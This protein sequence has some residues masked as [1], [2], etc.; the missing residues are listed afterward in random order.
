MAY[1]GIDLGTSSVKIIAMDESGKVIGSVSKEYPVYYPQPGWA[2]QNPEDWWTATRDGIRELL[3][4]TG[5]TG[6]K[7]QGIGL[8]GQM[9]G[10]VLLDENQQV[11]MPA[12]LWC[13]QRTQAECDHIMKTLGRERLSEYTGNKALTGFTAPKVLWVKKHHPD[14]HA[15]IRHILLPKDYIR[16]K[17]TGEFATD[18]SDASGTLFFDVA[19]RQWSAEMIDFL[20]IK[21]SSLP[22]CYES[23]E[24]TGGITSQAAAATGLK[25][26]TMV[27]GGGGDQA[28]GAVG[29]GAVN[30]G[31][32]SLALGT[33]GVVFACQE[34]Y[35]VD[36]ENRLHSFCHANG[37]W[38]VMGVMLSAASCL[39]WWVKE[40][41][42]SG[43]DAGYDRL[44]NEAA[45]VPAATGGLVFLPYLMGERTPHSDPY[46]RGSFVGLNMTHGRG[47]M[48]RAIMEG[49][50]F[51]LK[52]SFEIIRAQA[53]PVQAVRVS[54]GGAR[55]RLWRQILADILG[56]RVDLIGA[57]EGPAYGAA[58]LAAV[59]ARQFANVEEACA[60]FI[61][62]TDGVDP[63]P[64][65]LAPYQA[66]Y[67]VYQ[68]LYG[69]MKETFKTISML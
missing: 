68:G 50:G 19:R 57:V 67:Q 9:H 64:A 2:E 30:T 29:T 28:A 23:Y 41:C 25:T 24:P 27:V 17:L 47:H 11:L 38:H 31:T 66:M 51:G 49:V 55:S 62:V 58:I 13:D 45:N 18:V 42:Q 69:T 56:M 5:L 40:I 61:K 39:K 8:S 15:R 48:T 14:I 54:G 26:G 63:Q 43:S 53:I 6:E 46:A 37:K 12:L 52:D 16:L 20:T 33:S 34:Q 44:L 32:V 3:Y 22:A 4:K 60:A 36:P 59:G 1:L 35:S 21:P 10:M 65:S 7:V